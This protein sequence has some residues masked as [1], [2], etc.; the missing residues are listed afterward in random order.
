MSTERLKPEAALEAPSG[1]HPETHGSRAERAGLSQ[2]EREHLGRERMI[3]LVI[4]RAT[5][6]DIGDRLRAANHVK[7]AP[8]AW[9]HFEPGVCDVVDDRI[10]NGAERFTFKF[11]TDG[12]DNGMEVEEIIPLGRELKA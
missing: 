5:E 1:T 7:D 10:E 4:M 8:G 12:P 6:V 11:T 2:E 3:Q 9:R